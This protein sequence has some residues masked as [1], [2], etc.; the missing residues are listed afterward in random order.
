MIGG[1]LM[2]GAGM[3][4]VFYVGAAAAF[5]GIAAFVGVL[6]YDHGKQALSKW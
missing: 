1:V 5:G 3:A 6:T 4:W 2:T